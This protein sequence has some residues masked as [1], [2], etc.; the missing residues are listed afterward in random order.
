M[1]FPQITASL[2]IA[3]AALAIILSLRVSAAR[4]STGTLI[5]EIEND[6]LRRRV[7]AHGN[8]TEYA[9]L[10]LILLGLL[11]VRGSGSSAVPL[12]ATGFF[13][14][15]ILHVIGLSL[16]ARGQIA[17][18]I[19]AIGTLFCIAVTGLALTNALLQ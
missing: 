15:R 3:L 2:A 16:P 10:F 5:G 19:G 1:I 4:Q 9:P 17:R 14:M 7:R 18:A 8:L 12:L 13:C 11:E 6:A